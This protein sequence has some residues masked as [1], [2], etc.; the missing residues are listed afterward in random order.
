MDLESGPDTF[1]AGPGARA[2]TLSAQPA[3]SG[4]DDSQ[5]QL[6]FRVLLIGRTLRNLNRLRRGVGMDKIMI[7]AA[8]PF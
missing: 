7:A 8:E 5:I 4:P 6:K 2:K 3:C 1:A